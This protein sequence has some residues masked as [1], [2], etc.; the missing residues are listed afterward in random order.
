MHEKNPACGYHRGTQADRLHIKRYLSRF[1]SLARP[2]NIML[3]KD[4]TA[5]LGDF[6]SISNAE[7]RKAGEKHEFT[8]R[9]AAPESLVTN[10]FG[11]ESDIW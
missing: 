6:G 5:K 7:S 1:P 8:P 10:E 9:Y 4:F 2:A 3:G 11:P